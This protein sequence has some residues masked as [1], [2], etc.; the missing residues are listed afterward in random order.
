LLDV[1]LMSDTYL[2]LIPEDPEYIPVAEAQRRGL[3]ALRALVHQ[4]SHVEA[5]LFEQ[6]TFVDQGENFEKVECPGCDADVTDQWAEWMNKAFETQFSRLLLAMPCCGRGTS[7]NALRYSWP[8][9]FARFSLRAQN[10]GISGWLP[11][12]DLS[13]L[14]SLVGC[15]LRQVYARY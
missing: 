5:R 4:S 15:K 11:P 2:C 6:V 1:Q 8:A 3:A 12:E 14:E 13:V 10:P 9:G 7:L